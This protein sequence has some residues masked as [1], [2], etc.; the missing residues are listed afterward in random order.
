M[1]QPPISINI[2]NEGMIIS[3]PVGAGTSINT[4]IP[5]NTMN[6][7][8]ARWIETRREIKKQLVVAPGKA[9]AKI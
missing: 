1:E 3:T 2:S 8:V 4:F 9:I 7:I 5:E 6:Q